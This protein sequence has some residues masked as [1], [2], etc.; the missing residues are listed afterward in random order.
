MSSIIKVL[1]SNRLVSSPAYPKILIQYNELLAKNG[2]VNNKKFYEEVVKPEISNYSMQ[3]WYDF[4]KRF[5][6]SAGLIA[7]VISPEATNGTSL[8]NVEENEK[9]VVVT[10]QSNQAATATLISSI[11]NIS[12]SRAQ[13]IIEHPELLT[14]K[15]ALELGLKGMRAQDSRIHAV[16]KI[17]EDNREQ[18]RFD[19]AFDAASYGGE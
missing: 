13:D 8:K 9:K 11:L 14:A 12:A 6:T 5:K 19:R 10:M 4:T 17:R 7:A 3:A 2:K 1:P 18:E 16:G 15:E